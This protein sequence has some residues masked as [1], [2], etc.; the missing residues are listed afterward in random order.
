MI[1]SRR[2]TSYLEDDLLV[3]HTVRTLLVPIDTYLSQTYHKLCSS[4]IITTHKIKEKDVVSERGYKM[5]I[6]LDYVHII[7]PLYDIMESFH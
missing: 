2:T 4:D 7:H 5:L 6:C 1:C 3:L